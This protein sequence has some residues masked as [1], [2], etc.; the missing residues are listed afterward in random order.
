MS[1]YEEQAKALL[2]NP[3]SELGSRSPK[4]SGRKLLTFNIQT[5][6][7]FE[8]KLWSKLKKALP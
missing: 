1:R 3:L 6:N 8:E 2:T 5:F 4:V 7:P